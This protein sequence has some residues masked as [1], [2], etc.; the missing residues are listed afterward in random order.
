VAALTLALEDAALLRAAVGREGYAEIEQIAA[1]LDSLVRR[2]IID[3]GGPP[4]LLN[5]LACE[6][7]GQAVIHGAESL[8]G[9]V[10]LG[11]TPTSE[12]DPT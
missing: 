4:S 2:G 1:L 11:D 7:V 6:I 12:D 5:L 9:K 10:A 8:P 3:A